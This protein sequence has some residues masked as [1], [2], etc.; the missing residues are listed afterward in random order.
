MYIIHLTS[1][2]GSTLIIW[3]AF[4]QRCL[5]GRR[6]DYNKTTRR[7][8]TDYVIFLCGGPIAG[9]LKFNTPCLPRACPST[10]TL[11]EIRGVFG[12]LELSALVWES[13]PLFV[14]HES[15]KSPAEKNPVHHKAQQ[16]VYRNQIWLDLT[17]CGRAQISSYSLLSADTLALANCME[18]GHSAG[19]LLGLSSEGGSQVGVQVSNN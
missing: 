11:V 9:C 7:S 18:V 3:L 6:P 14:N 2:Q 8:M 17:A 5:L 15:A 16:Q 10:Y 13:T 19:Q 1:D 12:E 4:I